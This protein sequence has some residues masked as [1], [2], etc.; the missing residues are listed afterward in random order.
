VNGIAMLKHGRTAYGSGDPFSYATR[1]GSSVMHNGDAEAAVRMVMSDILIFLLFFVS[2]MVV[3]FNLPR[4]LAAVGGRSVSAARSALRTPSGSLKAEG[5]MVE[6][7]VDP[8]TP[9]ATS[10]WKL[11]VFED[12][13]L[14]SE[15]H[16]EPGELILGRGENVDIPLLDEVISAVHLAVRIG[17][18]LQLMIEDLGSTNGTWRH[19]TEQISSE[20]PQ[21]GDWYQMG[22]AQLVFTQE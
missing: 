19:G 22:R 13:A 8:P 11:S 18:D 7:V 14:T 21:A 4:I 16:L 17:D 20:T 15:H 9:E 10:R 5:Q 3:Q 12:A 6:E 2:G 1:L